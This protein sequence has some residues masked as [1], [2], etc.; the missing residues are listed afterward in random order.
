[1][2]ISERIRLN[3]TYFLLNLGF[4]GFVVCFCLWFFLCLPAGRKS[5]YL[6][7]V[8][9]TFVCVVL[10]TVVFDNVLVGTG[11]VAYDFDKI[12]GIFVG[13]APVEDFFYSLVAVSFLPAL[14]MLMFRFKIFNSGGVTFLAK[15]S[16]KQLLLSSRPLS[17][18]N[19]AFPFSVAYLLSTGGV[20]WFWVVGTFYFLVPYNLLMYGIN[21]VF[22]YESDL[23][24]P[25]KGGVEGALLSRSLHRLT[26]W[27]AVLSNL[28][29][30]VFLVVAGS[31]VSVLFLV[32]TVFMVL[33]YSAPKLRF[34]EKAF[35][36]SFTSSAH[37]VFPAVYG[38]VAAGVSLLDGS[39]AAFLGAFF[40]WGVASHAFGAVQD[41]VADRAGGI[42]SIATVVGGKLTVRLA[43]FCYVL[44][45]VLLLL[46]VW[47]WSL[48]F[49]FVVPYVL[50][51]LPFWFISDLDS[52]QANSGW[53]RFLGL[54]FF[55][56]FC[57]TMLFIF[58]I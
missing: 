14:W 58:F 43:V 37:F 12:S 53:K 22:D 15:N 27:V 46:L 31:G 11:I 51:L 40:L 41:I 8:V 26:I 23:R 17:W 1:M 16:V 7:S 48:T 57:V 2:C 25:R 13:Y 54:N 35:L 33:A 20:S 50:N 52:P 3:K 55:T 36:D 18:V 4:L 42:S 5:L 28:P 21:D 9:A 45:G 39:V 44:A 32:V 29:F 19:T 6:K 47:P 56:G 30:L 34:K 24:N 49:L 10:L 38:F